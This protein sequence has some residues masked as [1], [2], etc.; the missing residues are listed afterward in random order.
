MITL[1]DFEEFLKSKMSSY[2]FKNILNCDETGLF[3]KQ[4]S[5]W[6]YVLS[7]EDKANGK[8][9]KERITVLFAVSSTSEKLKPLVIGKSQKSLCHG[10]KNIEDFPTYYFSNKKSEWIRRFLGRE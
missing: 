1:G 8:F 10:N 2:E 6:T 3:Y 9:Y 7:D 4:C 5:T